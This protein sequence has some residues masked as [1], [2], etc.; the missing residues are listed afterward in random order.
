MHMFD[1]GLEDY[2]HF[3][4][5]GRALVDDGNIVQVALFCLAYGIL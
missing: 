2:F 4:M 1:L 5:G 3:S